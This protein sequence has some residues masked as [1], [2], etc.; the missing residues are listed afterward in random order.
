[1]LRR[2]V[3][4]AI[5]LVGLVLAHSGAR[6]QT[7]YYLGIGK[8]L[9]KGKPDSTTA[10]NTA[11]W[12][13][14]AIWINASCTGGGTGGNCDSIFFASYAIQVRAGRGAATDSLE[15][16]P[17]GVW[18][19]ATAP[20]AG[21]APDTLGGFVSTQADSLA[22]HADPTT[23]FVYVAN[24]S[25]EKSIH[26]LGHYIELTDPCN[27]GLWAAERTSIRIR[28]LDVYNAAGIV[29]RGASPDNR[30]FVTLEVYGWR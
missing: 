25:R 28:P 3:A 24:V 13:H 15:A 7:F 20:A 29:F 16:K 4:V 26:P 19:R 23:E 2:A 1:M 9:G 12:S 11:G 10:I 21:G 22:N 6:A 30:T 8:T 5:V 18:K 14:M 17:R 27:G